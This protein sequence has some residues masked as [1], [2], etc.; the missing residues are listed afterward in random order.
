[1]R[2]GIQRLVVVTLNTD[3]EKL[4]NIFITCNVDKAEATVL[5]DRERILKE[6]KA[7]MPFK[8]MNEKIK[9]ALIDSARIEVQR[10]KN[11]GEATITKVRTIEKLVKMLAFVSNYKEAE[12][13]AQK[14][15]DTCKEAFGL[16][17]SETATALHNLAT[18]LDDMQKY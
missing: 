3:F 10:V 5:A 12:F 17:H 14:S 1:M 15:F 7:S 4:K 13:F 18:V 6:I 8:E 2:L 9:K 11:S 16:E